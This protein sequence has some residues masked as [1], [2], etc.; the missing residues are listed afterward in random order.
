MSLQ[1]AKNALVT[2]LFE[3]SNAA[4]EAATATVNFYKA[5]GIDGADAAAEPLSTLGDSISGAVQTVIESV[6]EANG[7]APKKKAPRAKKAPKAKEPEKKDE[8]KPVEKPAE[9]P[10]EEP[11]AD[12]AEAKTGKP[13]K[14]EKPKRKRAE[15]DPNAPKKPLT[16]YLRF[17]LS[18]REQMRKE[19]FEN[20]QPTYPATELNQIISDRWANLSEDDKANLQKAYEGEFEVYKKA[21][22]QYNKEKTEA[23]KTQPADADTKAEAKVEVKEKAPVKAKKSASKKANGEA[24]TV[25]NAIAAAAAEVAKAEAKPESKETKS[26]EPTKKSKKRKDKDGEEKKSKKKKSE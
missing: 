12:E 9:K 3:L 14:P 5:A 2:S 11:V 1:L 10:A 19:R 25:E 17:N 15:K 24:L 13:D 18:V 22:E 26:S 20:G 4:T 21:L 8:E 6:P 16:S 23:S 7:D